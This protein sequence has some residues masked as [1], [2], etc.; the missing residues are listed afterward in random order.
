MKGL[1]GI[2]KIAA[3][4]IAVVFGASSALAAVDLGHYPAPFVEDGKVESQLVL[5]ENAA[6]ID[7]IGAVNI[8]ASFSAAGGEGTVVIEGEEGLVANA[9]PLEDENNEFPAKGSTAELDFDEMD[10]AWRHFVGYGDDDIE[11]LLEVEVTA[12]EDTDNEPIIEVNEMTYTI[13]YGGTDLEDEI[14]FYVDELDGEEATFRYRIDLL[15]KTYYVVSDWDG[16]DFDDPTLQLAHVSVYK[17]VG[18]EV[19]LTDYGYDGYTLL[20]EE[21]YEAGSAGL[22]G[23]VTFSLLDEDG[24]VVDTETVTD[25]SEVGTNRAR[26]RDRSNDVAVNVYLD[27]VFFSAQTSTYTAKFSMEAGRITEGQ[28]IE[29]N[30]L[31][32]LNSIEIDDENGEIEIVIDFQPDDADD[33]EIYEGDQLSLMG[34]AA[35]GFAGL[36]QQRFGDFMIQQTKFDGYAGATVDE[37]VLEFGSGIRSINIDGRRFRGEKVTLEY[38]S[39]DTWEITKLDVGD[40]DDF[41]FNT[42]ITFKVGDSEYTL[43]YEEVVFTLD[44]DKGE[45]D[46]DI[47]MDGD[48]EWANAYIEGDTTNLRTGDRSDMGVR[49]VEY[50]QNGFAHFSLPDDIVRYRVYAGKDVVTTEPGKSTVGVGDVADGTIISVGGSAL[51]VGLAIMDTDLRTPDAVETGNYIVIGGPCANAA[52]AAL[53]GYPEPCNE[54]FEPGKAMIKL[55]EFEDSYALLVA[56]WEGPD[57]LLATE[58]LGKFADFADELEGKTEVTISGTTLSNVNIN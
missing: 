25:D 20:V 42:S 46:F 26:L 39:V 1:K 35:V 19:D 9:V 7:V 17:Q 50:R 37:I 58:V 43:T 45:E 31:W 12:G 27:N 57:T 16:A 54:G 56:G 41:T 53:L 24:L 6:V 13:T 10:S 32:V 48:G 15:G 29:T 30:K 51:P 55:F 21:I 33:A 11:E 49:V 22:S 3:L 47:D 52:A 18:A 4:G 14:D 2:T 40:E 28:Y 5:G 34:Y 8:A 36:T 38:D 44:W 23:F